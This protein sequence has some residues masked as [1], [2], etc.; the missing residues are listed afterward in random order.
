MNKRKNLKTRL[1]IAILLSALFLVVTGTARA[2]PNPAAVYCTLQGY[3]YQIRTD[4]QG[5]QYGVCV[6]PDGSEC[7]GWAY[8]RK[9]YVGE[10]TDCHWPC[11]E[12]RCKEAGESVL[13]SKCCEGLDEIFPPHIFDANCNNLEL[14]GWLFLCSDCGNGIC[15]SWESKCNCP[16]D[17]GQ[18]R[19]IYVDANAPGANNGSSWAN[20]YNFLQD[21]LTD[22][23]SSP[24]PVQIC[25]AEGIYT[26][27]SN[28]AEPNGTGDREATFHLINGVTIKGGY[29]GFSEQ[30]PNA[31]DIEVFETILSGDLNSDD[32]EFD[33]PL[34]LEYAS[35]RNENSYH[36]VI[37]SGTDAT[38]VLDGFTITA[39]NANA[40]SWTNKC[41][42]GMYNNVGSPT[43]INCTFSWNGGNFDSYAGGMANLNNSNPILVNCTFSHNAASWPGGGGMGNDNES[44]PTL[45]N[46][47]FIGNK[48]GGI[49]S[50]KAGA[51]D[52]WEASSPTL[53]NCVFIGNYA[54]G[55]AGAIRSGGNYVD[56]VSSPTLINCT[57]V[58]NS[59]GYRGGAIIQ[60]SGTLRL[61]N[62][63]M[64]DNTAPEGN[65]MYLQHG[66]QVDATV[67]VSYSDIE[68]GRSGFYI[69]QG[70]TLNWGV[71]NIDEDPCFADP[72]YWADANDPN[73][74]VE[75]NDP[76][77]VWIDGD[78]H[79]KSQAGR[80]EPATQAWI[81]DDVTSLCIDAGDMASPIGLEPFPNGGIINMGAFGGTAEAS[82]SYFGQPVCETIV[83]GD[84]NGD[85]KIDYRDVLLMCRN[86]LVEN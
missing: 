77:A 84:I 4:E 17:C 69:E 52:N 73:I 50:G 74:I 29:A 55:L 85:C 5:N 2:M 83:A 39:G 10:A 81:V 45:T 60:E 27:D 8:Y 37:G 31:R 42:S 66:Y 71:G 65:V 48:S 76:N 13:L 70:C 56:T 79:L 49:D 78:Y 75:P 68:G 11:K 19:I 9:C 14:I 15:E 58:G 59:A 18:P 40:G 64:W 6:F 57:F 3:E 41:G 61:T 46:C 28:S 34:D 63:I 82:K 36:V 62:C 33:D 7:Y 51:M 72:G 86:W 47:L 35:C 80:W 53:I 32:V 44:S 12:M 21:A 24:K 38:A 43:V 25:V 54:E 16:E 22:A 20:A 67:N 1:I 30:D 26:P 23:N